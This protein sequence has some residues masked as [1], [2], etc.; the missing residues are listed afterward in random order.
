VD[1]GF[2]EMKRALAEPSVKDREIEEAARRQLHDKFLT[3]TFSE[4]C[5]LTLSSKPPESLYQCIAEIYGRQNSFAYSQDRDTN[6]QGSRKSS[7]SVDTT[8]LMSPLKPT[9]KKPLY[10]EYFPELF[11]Y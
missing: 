2:A 9:I 3:A 8:D 6:S 7:L 1:V 10:E 4:L 5:S 11:M